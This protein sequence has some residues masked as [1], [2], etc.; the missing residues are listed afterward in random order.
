MTQ[1]TSNES[2]IFHLLTFKKK[3]S[4]GEW[5]VVL[6]SLSDGVGGG[7]PSLLYFF[8]RGNS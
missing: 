8:K 1:L 4:L 6:S 7:K 5:F 3:I 2:K